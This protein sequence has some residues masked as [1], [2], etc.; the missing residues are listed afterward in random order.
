VSIEEEKIESYLV[1]DEDGSEHLINVF[2][3]VRISIFAGA[4]NKTYGSICHRMK[5]GNHVNVLSGG[6]VE[7]FVTGKKMRRS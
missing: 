3:E 1:I 4:K 5:N 7:D 6:V 2:R